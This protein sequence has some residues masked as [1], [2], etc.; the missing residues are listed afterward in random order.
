MYYSEENDLSDDEDDYCEFPD[1]I[2]KE[3]E[4]DKKIQIISTFKNYIK[5]SPEFIGI[6]NM[7]SSKLLNI[8]ES[9]KVIKNNNYLYDEQMK[10]FD[11]LYK[12]LYNNTGNYLLY[13]SIAKK[14]F[15]II[16]V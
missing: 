10:L 11:N 9:N 7:S 14:I 15:N 3:F 8:I 4:Y 1:D 16:Y 6:K 2:L 5:H 12:E 13:N